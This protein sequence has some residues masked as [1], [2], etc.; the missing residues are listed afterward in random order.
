[1]KI[2]TKSNTIQ[3]RNI[4]PL[5]YPGSKLKLIPT[6][7]E[8][9]DHNKINPQLL[10]EPFI[11]GGNVAL[12]FLANSVVDKAIIADKDRLIYS[13]WYSVFAEH[14]RLVKFAR[15]VRVTYRNFQKYKRIARDVKQFDTMTLAKTCLFLNR[16]SFSGLLTDRAGPLGGKSQSSKY[17]LDCRFN[18]KRIVEKIRFIAAFRDR[19]I[20]LPYDWRET[21]EYAIKWAK[22]AGVTVG[23]LFYFDPPFYNKASELYREYFTADD[24]KTFRDALAELRHNWVL[25]YDNAPEVQDL[26]SRKRFAKIHI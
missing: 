14:K 16:V 19:V 10:V 2:R 8:I 26:Y 7:A 18:R 9:I 4:S 5:R 15:T 21:I 13:F 3:A 22:S 20:V 24:H 11:G 25:S 6:L 17:P 1:M 12:N 23:I